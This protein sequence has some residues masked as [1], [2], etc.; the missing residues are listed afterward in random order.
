MLLHYFITIIYSSLLTLKQ[1]KED[2][3]KLKMWSVIAKAACELWSGAA[4]RLGRSSN[5]T[6]KG[7]RRAWCSRAPNHTP[8]RVDPAYGP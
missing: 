6:G 5:A 7:A 1:K 2:V 8:P 4:A 3:P